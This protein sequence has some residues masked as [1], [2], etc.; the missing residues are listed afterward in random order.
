MVLAVDFLMLRLLLE[1]GVANILGICV[2]SQRVN[3]YVHIAVYARAGG[4]E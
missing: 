1:V 3:A 2:R 4:L